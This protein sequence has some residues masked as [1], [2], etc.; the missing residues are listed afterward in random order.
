[1]CFS[2]APETP[3]LICA[4]L[5][6]PESKANEDTLIHC[7][8]A[9]PSNGFTKS[10]AREL[11]KEVAYGLRHTFGIGAKGAGKDVVICISSGQTLL[12]AL[13]Y[14][15]IAAGGVYSAA[16]A[17]FTA[18]ELSRQIKQGNS[19]LIFCSEDAK[20]V[21]CQAAIDCG[22]PLSRVLVL[23]SSPRWSMKC[24]EGGKTCLP[25]GGKLDWERITDPKTLENSLIC[26]LYSSGTTGI[27]KG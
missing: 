8:A 10:Q 20:E 12:P 21:A 19:N 11:T 15:V 14:G 16:S 24:V 13:F 22:L 17:S 2:N 1:V 23:S 26:L 5:E 4:W 18:P 27:P 6:N 9:D 7:D 25:S 3:L